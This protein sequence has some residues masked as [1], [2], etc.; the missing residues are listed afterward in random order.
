[1]TVSLGPIETRKLRLHRKQSQKKRE[2]KESIR[3]GQG[4]EIMHT[5]VLRV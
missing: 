1:M 2:I 5:T 4:I 3:V